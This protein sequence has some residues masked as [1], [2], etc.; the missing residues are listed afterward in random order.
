MGQGATDASD[1]GSARGRVHDEDQTVILPRVDAG[2]ARGADARAQELL[3]Q[4]LLADVPWPD[5]NAAAAGERSAAELASSLAAGLATFPYL[6]RTIRRRARFWC[7]LGAVGLAAGVG[8]HYVKPPP[9]KAVT[10]VEI[11]DGP[12]SN[13]IDAITTQVA[14]V[15]SRAVA[16]QAEHDLGLT[17]NVSKFLASYTAASV[18]DRIISITAS[19]PSRTEALNRANKLAEV[20]LQFQASQ[21]RLQQQGVSQQLNRQIAALYQQIGADKS[22]IAKARSP[23]ATSSQKASLGQLT[24]QEKRDATNLN[25]LDKAL[26]DYELSNQVANAQIVSG[27]AVL[28]SAALL[29]PSKV[30]SPAVYAVGGLAAGLVAGIGIVI[31]GALVTDRLRRRDDIAR[32]LAAPVQLSV[33][34]VRARRHSR[35]GLAVIR[36]RHLQRVVAYLDGLLPERAS[37]RAPALVVIPLDAPRTGARAVAA[38]ALARAQRDQKVVVADLADGA[39]AARLLGVRDHGTHEVDIAGQK[40]T[41]IVPAGLAPAGPVSKPGPAEHQTRPAADPD[42]AAAY[43]DADLLL[44]LAVADPAVGADYLRSWGTGSVVLVTAGQ[45]SASKLHATAEMIRLAGLRIVSAVLLGT[46]RTDD[47][48]G[49]WVPAGPDTDGG[50]PEN[51]RVDPVDALL[52]AVVKADRSS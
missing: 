10:S 15:Q 4:E 7:I 39:P 45:N 34:R 8:L 36:D 52:S 12:A 17:E 14:L 26:Q 29:P 19:A 46:D 18:T 41:V 22:A 43:S 16:K 50:Y 32:A 31:I 37:R 6:G 33:G 5:D 42:I 38:L 27:S 44:T 47:S 20:Y 30:K 3:A 24:G 25:G 28:D 1:A 23:L 51:G 11:T 35:R 48:I 9:F 40:L 21:L 13:P 2:Q 49:A